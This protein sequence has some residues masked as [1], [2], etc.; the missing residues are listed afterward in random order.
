[1]TK[2]I[3]V[4]E[5]QWYA[6]RDT[7][8]AAFEAC[9]ERDGSLVEVRFADI[10]DQ[11]WL[12]PG[13]DD[14]EM[15]RDAAE[16]NLAPCV[17]ASIVLGK[18]VMCKIDTIN[19]T[20]MSLIRQDTED[21]CGGEITIVVTAEHIAAIRLLPGPVTREIDGAEFNLRADGGLT[22]GDVD[23]PE[24]TFDRDDVLEIHRMLGEHIAATVPDNERLLKP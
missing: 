7:V 19:D 13:D 16:E 20:M 22:I 3:N 12:S 4:Q 17:L 11:V 6:S 15:I 18:P 23:D 14:T 9:Q 5:N 21:D 2:R 1:M 24:F 10:K 8:E